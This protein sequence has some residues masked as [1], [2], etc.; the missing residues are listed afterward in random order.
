MHPESVNRSTAYEDLKGYTKIL[1]YLFCE[2]AV[3]PYR[4]EDLYSI[5]IS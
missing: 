1:K 4:K 5:I 2:A 3:G